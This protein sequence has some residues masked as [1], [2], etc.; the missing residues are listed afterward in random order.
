MCQCAKGTFRLAHTRES[1]GDVSFGSLAIHIKNLGEA[2]TPSEALLF[3]V[4]KTKHLLVF[5]FYNVARQNVP[6]TRFGVPRC[7]YG[8]RKVPLACLSWRALARWLKAHGLG[9]IPLK[10]LV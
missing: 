2:S 8:K 3:E 5:Y 6:L 1:Q 9:E 10:T 4:P 7:K